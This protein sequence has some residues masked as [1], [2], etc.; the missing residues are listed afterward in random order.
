MSAPVKKSASIAKDRL[1]IILRTQREEREGPDFMPS[2]SREL[3][4]L[5]S[6]HVQ[7]PPEDIQIIIDRVDDHEVLE[8]CVRLPGARG[9][10]E[11]EEA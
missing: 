2:L 3:R 7:V 1:R 11:G 4:D 8:M 6:R 5:I 9:P 10:Q